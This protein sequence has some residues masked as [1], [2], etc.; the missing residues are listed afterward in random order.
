VEHI[1]DLVAAVVWP[2]VLVGLL[3]YFREPIRI[4]LLP[5]LT[6]VRA[7]GFEFSF[8]E[9]ALAAASEGKPAVTEASRSAALA[10]L[11]RNAHLLA[12]A[13][14][15]W[16][17]D[18]PRNNFNERRL[19]ERVGA[20]IDPALKTDDALKLAR[21]HPYD[22]I[23]SDW[24]RPEGDNAGPDLIAALRGERVSTPV[25]FYAGRVQGRSRGEAIGLTN[26]PDELV[27]IVLDVLQ[28]ERRAVSTTMP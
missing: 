18:I 24:K 27:H 11:R 17:D 25:V 20:R 22:L 6:G 16:V 23:I 19:F 13:R 9:Q 4:Q 8:A 28:A 21:L 1:V 3:W 12:G 14:I 15:L 7:F 10:R 2:L 5:R 26:R